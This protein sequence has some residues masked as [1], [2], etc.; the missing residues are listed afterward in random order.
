MTSRVVA[1][2]V[3]ALVSAGCQSAHVALPGPAKNTVSPPP[4][5]L[6]KSFWI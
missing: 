1:L 5:P 4:A 2:I 3:L 6:I